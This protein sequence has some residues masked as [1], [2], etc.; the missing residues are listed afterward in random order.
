[1]CFK[2]TDK[3]FCDKH[4]QGTFMNYKDNVDVADEYYL[5]GKLCITL[6]IFFI[7]RGSRSLAGSAALGRFLKAVGAPHSFS[8]S[9]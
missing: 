2:S 1:M 6:A 7:S 4:E 8:G 9:H 5:I 3:L